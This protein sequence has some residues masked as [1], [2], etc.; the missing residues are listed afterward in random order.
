MLFKRKNKGFETARQ[1]GIRAWRILVVNSMLSEN[2][3]TKR[4]YR[5]T[6]EELAQISGVKP[7]NLMLGRSAKDLI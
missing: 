7:E 1:D 4:Q 5:W 2:Y 3:L 6:I